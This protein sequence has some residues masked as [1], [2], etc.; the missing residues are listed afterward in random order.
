MEIKS[1]LIRMIQLGL[2]TVR[3]REIVWISMEFI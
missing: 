2:I 1:G 3:I